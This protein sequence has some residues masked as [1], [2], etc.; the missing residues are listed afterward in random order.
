MRVLA[1]RPSRILGVDPG[2]S[3]T[4]FGV[5]ERRGAQIRHVAHGTLRPARGASLAERLAV[6]Q[7]GLAGAIAAHRP[8]VAVIE[9]VFAGRSARSALVLGHARGVALATAAA[10][11]LAVCEYT[12]PEIKLAV[13]GSGAAQKRQVQAMVARLLALEACPAFDAADA[14]AAALCHAHRGP[15]AALAAA[16]SGRRRAAAHGAGRLVVRRAR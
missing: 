9:R 3:V 8:E 1:Q 7:A 14:L 15:L 5:V 2:S 16:A 6:I 12:A 10:A 13:A 4:G 11:G